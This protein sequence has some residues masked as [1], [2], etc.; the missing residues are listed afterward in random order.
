MKKLLVLFLALLLVFPAAALADPLPLEEDLSGTFTVLYDEEDPAAGGYVYSFRY[1]HVDPAH[2][3][4]HLVNEFYEYLARDTEVYTVPNLSDYYAG[5]GQRVAVSVTYEVT[6][7]T[8]RFFS[9]RI[10]RVMEAEGDEPAETWEADSFSRIDGRPGTDLTLTNL[11]GTLDVG[12]TDEWL[13]TRQ[14][15]KAQNAVLSLVWALIEENPQGIPYY[16]DLT[17]E[18]LGWLLDPDQD[19]WLDESENPVFFL[20]A[21]AAA[22]PEAGLLTFPL[23]LSAIYDEL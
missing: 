20:R 23:S 16:E 2:P 21:G 17:K 12:E 11:L 13:E 22:D 5:I 18:E 19:F 4:A 1:P 6:C 10:H 9:V 15:R 14:T 8:D 3:D 7:N